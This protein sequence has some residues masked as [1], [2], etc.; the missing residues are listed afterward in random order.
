MQQYD[1]YI[2]LSGT[3]G[4]PPAHT[5]STPI[6]V[7][8]KITPVSVFSI[9]LITLFA[10]SSLQQSSKECSQVLKEKWIWFLS[11]HLSNHRACNIR[12]WWSLIS[13]LVTTWHFN[14]TARYS[15]NQSSLHPWGVWYSNPNYMYVYNIY[16][17]IYVIRTYRHIYSY[18]CIITKTNHH[19]TLEV[20]DTVTLITYMYI[21]YIYIY[22]CY[23]YI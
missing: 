21:I 3:F 10:E 15:Q 14:A 18:I 5:L 16:I 2:Y 20:F 6:T 12:K 23:T 19:Y 1:W 17:Y 22:I 9:S 11:F 13:S 7:P 4:T 8:P